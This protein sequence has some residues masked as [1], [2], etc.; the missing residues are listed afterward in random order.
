[1]DFVACKFRTPTLYS[2][3]PKPIPGSRGLMRY[4]RCVATLSLG[5]T[6]NNRAQDH[7]NFDSGLSPFA[8][9]FEKP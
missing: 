6:P 5:V 1:V 7:L 2:A 4:K 9:K 8:V 3:W